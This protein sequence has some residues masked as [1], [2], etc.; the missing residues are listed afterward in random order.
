[1]PLKKGRSKKTLASNIKKTMGEYR[2]TGKIGS[3]RPKSAR[4]AQ[5]QAVAVAY[6]ARKR[7]GKRR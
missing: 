2:K 3:S 5:K 4:K 1:M 6:S 7:S